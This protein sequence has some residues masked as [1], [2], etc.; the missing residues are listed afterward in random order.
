MTAERTHGLAR[1][2]WANHRGH[3]S[4]FCSLVHDERN[5]NR[6]WAGNVF[7]QVPPEERRAAETALARPRAPPS[8]HQVSPEI[9]TH[10]WQLP[11]CASNAGAQPICQSARLRRSSEAP[12]PAAST[13][14][15]TAKL[16]SIRCRARSGA[17]GRCCTWGGHPSHSQDAATSRGEVGSRAGARSRERSRSRGSLCIYEGRQSARPA[18]AASV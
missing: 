13:L 4:H 14:P 11:R 1:A 16:K 3:K 17:P 18:E 2:A 9:N 5:Y 15:E 8:V 10:S 12:L 7:A 6:K